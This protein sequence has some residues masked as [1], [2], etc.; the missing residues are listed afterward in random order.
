MSSFG[1]PVTRS[2]TSYYS[3]PSTIVQESI[4]RMLMD[5][6]EHWRSSSSKRWADARTELQCT[7][8]CS[9]LVN[10]VYW[11]SY[12][13]LLIIITR[14]C[15][16]MYISHCVGGST[17]VQQR[18]YPN[19]V[20]PYWNKLK[21]RDPNSLPDEQ[22]HQRPLNCGFDHTPNPRMDFYDKEVEL[23]MGLT[24]H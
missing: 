5:F 10:R 9:L 19:V 12:A 24:C 1:S 22:L 11:Y 2:T 8:R 15:G 16:H 14:S 4:Y 3:T 6:Q 17:G 18:Q 7:V 13:S 23:C 21:M 20:S